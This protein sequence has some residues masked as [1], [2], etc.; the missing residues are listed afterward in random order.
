MYNVNVL[1]VTE[2]YIFE[3]VKMV[4][5]V[6]WVFYHN[7]KKKKKN[8]PCNTGKKIGGS[9]ETFYSSLARV[10]LYRLNL[11]INMLLTCTKTNQKKGQATSDG[12]L[13][14]LPNLPQ[15]E[16]TQGTQKGVVSQAGVMHTPQPHQKL[17]IQVI[18]PGMGACALLSG[19]HSGP[20]RAR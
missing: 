15:Q 19:L 8:N 9:L 16:P 11:I 4:R 5:F 1:N 3:M 10:I 17:P 18:F 14:W 2:L 7:L 13:A 6:L 20:L 12:G